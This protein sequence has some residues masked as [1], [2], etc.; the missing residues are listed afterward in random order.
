[1]NREQSLKLYYENPNHCKECGKVIE[2]LDNQ[3][4]ADVR[5]KQFCSHSCAASYNNRGSTMK[6]RYVLD[7]VNLSI[8]IQKCVVV[9]GK[10]LMELVTKH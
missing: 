6:T 1:M 9:A 2:V 10:N 7:V 5:K 3:R 8:K 4:V